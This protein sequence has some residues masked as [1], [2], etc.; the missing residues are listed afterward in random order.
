MIVVTGTK[1]SGTSL[2]MQ[3]LKAAKFPIIGE[4]FLGHW[5]ESIH[6]ANVG[7]FY[8]SKLRY[9][10]NHSNNPDVQTGQYLHPRTVV[11]HGVKIFVPGLIK[12]EL[13]FLHRIIATIRPWREYCHSI[14]RLQEMEANHWLSLPDISEKMPQQV[15]VIL[16]QS[17]IHPSLVWWR[18]NVALLADSRSRGYPIRLIPY[19][20]LLN[21]SEE[22]L[23]E[24]LDWLQTG[25]K[26]DLFS[27][28]HTSI[29]IESAIQRVQ[30]GLQTQQS[31]PVSDSPL[32]THQEFLFDE[33]YRHSLL[34]INGFSD[35][36]LQAINEQ[37]PRIEGLIHVQEQEGR[38]LKHDQL[39]ALGK[40]SSVAWKLIQKTEQKRR[41]RYDRRVASPLQI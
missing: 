12:T 6:L 17:T 4:P 31:T 7:G 35:G 36:F 18:D 40:T 39:T 21:Q 22:I 10:I 38:Q 41:H 33:L 3:I 25:I 26:Q 28:E 37:N 11:H 29:D 13:T 32:T 34:G 16:K 2:W 15:K 27:K 24:V 20:V 30:P 23:P 14:R 1:R 9:G 5:K 19:E 8:E